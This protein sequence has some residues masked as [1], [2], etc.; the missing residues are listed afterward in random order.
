MTLK[1]LYEEL[2]KIIDTE[3]KT[4]PDALNKPIVLCVTP[5]STKAEDLI[6]CGVYG[7]GNIINNEDVI[8]I[9]N[10]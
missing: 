8:T 10:Y 3:C 4:N 1:K 5:C 2:S 7:V 6:R 9:T